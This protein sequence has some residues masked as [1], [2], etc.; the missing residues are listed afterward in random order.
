MKSIR[1]MR[2]LKTV[3]SVLAHWCPLF[4]QVDY[5][6]ALLFPFVKIFE[7]N[8]LITFEAIYTVLINYCQFWF[9]YHP[10]PPINILL[11]IEN[12]LA[13]HCDTLMKYYSDLEITP[14]EYAWPIL[15]TGFSEILDADQWCSLWDNV[16]TNDTSFLLLAV[17][18]YNIIQRNI[19]T[20]HQTRDECC[21]FFHNKNH[22]DMTLFLKT[23]YDLN[24]STSDEN[25]PN[26]FLKDFTPLPKDTYAV[27]TGYP[28]DIVEYQIDKLEQIE[29]EEQEILRQE[30]EALEKIQNQQERIRD[31]ISKEEHAKR[32][33]G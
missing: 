28:K 3:L 5:L 23:I 1:T 16:L 18:A 8:A 21:D 24:K 26:C 17:V 22:L 4:S 29:Q 7:N 9:E 6:P 27:F 33:E 31:G 15:S 12:V 32:L 20:Q 19:I 14:Q 11:I 25:H 2:N 30:M 13:E 10:S